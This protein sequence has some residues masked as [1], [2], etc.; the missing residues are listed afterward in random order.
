MNHFNSPI[1]Q[2]NEVARQYTPVQDDGDNQE[3]GK[4]KAVEYKCLLAEDLQ[5]IRR[6]NH[7]SHHIRR[8]VADEEDEHDEFIKGLLYPRLEASSTTSIEFFDDD[9]AVSQS[10]NRPSTSDVAAYPSTSNNHRANNEPS[11]LR[12]YTNYHAH[13]FAPMSDKYS[14][15]TSEKLRR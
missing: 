3:D 7:S 8:E 4:P 15:V 10:Q 2:T 1:S 14:D 11:Q 9:A 6:S 5:K 13:Y 12:G